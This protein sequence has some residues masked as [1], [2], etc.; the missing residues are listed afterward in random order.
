MLEIKTYEEEKEVD[1]LVD[2]EP[3]RVSVVDHGANGKRFY[4]KNANGTKYKIAKISHPKF[5]QLSEEETVD[6]TETFKNF[7]NK[8]IDNPELEP[9]EEGDNLVVKSSDY[10]PNMSYIEINLADGF[11]I[12]VE[13][14]EIFNLDK[15]QE[16]ICDTVSVDSTEDKMLDDLKELF[17]KGAEIL[18][19][20][21]NSDSKKEVLKEEGEKAEAEVEVVAEEAKEEPKVDLEKAL[22][23]SEAQIKELKEKNESLT[24]N[25]EKIKEENAEVAKVLKQFGEIVET[26]QAKNSELEKAVES[27]SAD[28]A[29]KID[30]LNYS[31]SSNSEADTKE[32]EKKEEEKTYSL[33]D[34]GGT[35]AAL[36]GG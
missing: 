17:N 22:A 4:L 9:S 35:F 36:F 26:L 10:D 23:D 21:E 24:A 34:E 13:K 27:K 12:L 7:I 32:I 8:N 14:K 3:K 30:S 1:Y 29:K 11:Q 18:E 28:L 16:K 31:V 2:V 15:S 19:K 20:F 5:V 25:L 33:K 6:Y